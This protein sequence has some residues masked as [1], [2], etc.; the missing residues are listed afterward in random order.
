MRDTRVINGIRLPDDSS[1]TDNEKAWV[2]IIRLLS[3]GSDPVPTLRSVQALRQVLAG[4][5]FP[6]G[7]DR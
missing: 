4:A 3:Q 5:G 2:E 1:L 6:S 7:L